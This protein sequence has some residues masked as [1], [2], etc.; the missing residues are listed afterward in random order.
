[1]KFGTTLIAM[2]LAGL[3]TAISTNTSADEAP[4]TMNRPWGMESPAGVAVVDNPVYSKACGGSC[5]MVYPP[6]LLP[7]QSWER[8][9][10]TL[11]D[12]FGVK[13]TPSRDETAAIFRYLL[14]NAAGRVDYTVSNAIVLG[15]SGVPL[16]ITD[17]P[18]FRGKHQEVASSAASG[19]LADCRACHSRAEQGSFA[20]QEIV[21]DQML[22]RAVP[23]NEQQTQP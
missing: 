18:Y 17:L 13:L 14:N 1:M 21:D 7:A 8:L 16:R 15:F 10:T 5:H 12:H 22:K 2:T 19:S 23:R 11:D 9:M 6:G 3:A 4:D 20:K